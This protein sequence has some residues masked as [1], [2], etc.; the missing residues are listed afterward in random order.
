MDFLPQPCQQLHAVQEIL[1]VSRHI[2][3]RLTRLTENRAK[4]VTLIRLW[5]P[6]KTIGLSGVSARWTSLS[7]EICSDLFSGE[8]KTRVCS[9]SKSHDRTVQSLK[10]ENGN[11]MNHIKFE[12]CYYLLKTRE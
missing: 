7:A 1:Q 9:V 2:C 10:Q 6:K 3:I 11:V 12:H 5:K 4:P 8:C